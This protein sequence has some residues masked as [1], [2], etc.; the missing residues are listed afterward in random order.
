[1]R[2]EKAKLLQQQ[3]QQHQ[4]NTEQQDKSLINNQIE[5]A[6]CHLCS[7]YWPR[8]NCRCCCCDCCFGDLP[9]LTAA[10]LPGQTLEDKTELLLIHTAKEAAGTIRGKREREKAEPAIDRVTG[11]SMQHTLRVHR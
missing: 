4:V 6:A 10:D 1:M 3:Q 11:K 2:K 5:E 7:I 9:M 8:E